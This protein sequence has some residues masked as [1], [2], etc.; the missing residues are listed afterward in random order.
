MVALDYLS[1]PVTEIDHIACVTVTV[2]P[3]PMTETSHW[4]DPGHDVAATWCTTCCCPQHAVS[5]SSARFTK[6]MPHPTGLWHEQF[7]SFSRW[8]GDITVSEDEQTRTPKFVPKLVLSMIVKPV[9]STVPG[10][11]DLI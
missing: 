5:S 9:H 7:L 1:K 11:Q 8:K 3:G 4:Q 6:L 2:S 10:R